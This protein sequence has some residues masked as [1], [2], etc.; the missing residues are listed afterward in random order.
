M[1]V[2]GNVPKLHTIAYK[3]G[4]SSA[5][6]Y[7]KVYHRLSGLVKGKILT[8][9]SPR[10]WQRR[11]VAYHAGLSRPQLAVR[12]MGENGLQSLRD[13]FVVASNGHN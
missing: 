1:R 6:S 12:K 10:H 2:C 8:R 3:W 5:V 11:H 7:S 4:I 9:A 13:R